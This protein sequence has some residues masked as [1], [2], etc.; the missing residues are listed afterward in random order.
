V[1]LEAG[2][3]DAPDSTTPLTEA[4]KNAA[5]ASLATRWSYQIGARTLVVWAF[6]IDTAQLEFRSAT[7]YAEA[8]A[9][10]ILAGM[11][12]DNDASAAAASFLDRLILVPPGDA[13]AALAHLRAV[14]TP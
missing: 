11:L 7:T 4:F 2:Y 14:A 12:K 8:Q 5:G 13:D 6:R 9:V 10:D 3:L 1:W